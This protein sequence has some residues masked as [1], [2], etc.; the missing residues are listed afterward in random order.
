[1]NG[2][3]WGFMRN[4]MK[5]SPTELRQ[6]KEI[7]YKEA[8]KPYLKPRISKNINK[9]FKIIKAK[10]INFN[11][12]TTHIIKTESNILNCASQSKL[13]TKCKEFKLLSEFSSHSNC[14]KNCKKLLSLNYDVVILEGTGKECTQCLDF[15]TWDK[16]GY[17]KNTLD[18]KSIYCRECLS[19]NMKLK[20]WTNINLRFSGALRNRINTV[21]K[22]NKKSASTDELTGCTIDELRTRFE[23]LFQPGMT[24]D[25]HGIGKNGKEMKEWH[26]DH[27]KPCASFDLSKDEEQ[28]KCFHFSNLQPLWAKENLIKSGNL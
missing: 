23:R 1:M 27:I 24:W 28:R 4:N 12:R 7:L 3:F 18:K 5:L 19:L 10:R 2:L 17:C 26:I 13:C 8:N 22:L 21:L 15:K 6:I 11:K 9:S 14:C 25:N 20:R 16:Y